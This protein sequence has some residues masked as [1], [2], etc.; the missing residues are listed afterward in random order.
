MLTYQKGYCSFYQI[1][2]LTRVHWYTIDIPIHLEDFFSII[3]KYQVYIVILQ[4]Q[5]IV[6]NTISNLPLRE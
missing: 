6:R 4:H 2:Y 1:I 3:I 5:L